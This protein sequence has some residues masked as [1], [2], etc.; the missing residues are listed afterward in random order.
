MYTLTAVEASGPVGPAKGWE[1]P[2]EP[3][4]GPV[5]LRSEQQEASAEVGPAVEVVVSEG[6]LPQLSEAALEQKQP[7]WELLLQLVV[8]Q[9]WPEVEQ[10]L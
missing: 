6:V 5:E 10:V 3:L 1:V 7:V 9:V 2:E 8:V 4:A